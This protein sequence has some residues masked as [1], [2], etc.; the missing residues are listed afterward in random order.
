MIKT[1]K[2]TIMKK[3]LIFCIMLSTS[4]LISHEPGIY[5]VKQENFFIR[6]AQWF[7]FLFPKQPHGVHTTN[8][9]LITDPVTNY[10]TTA[11]QAIIHNRINNIHASNDAITNLFE[12]IE[13][14]PRTVASWKSPLTGDNVAHIICRQ[15][16]QPIHS[17]TS[18]KLTDL[19]K[20]LRKLVRAGLNINQKNNQTE[21]PLSTTALLK[22]STVD[23]IE[24]LV[25]CGA[26]PYI[27][28]TCKNE[29]EITPQPKTIQTIDQIDTSNIENTDPN[30]TINVTIN[31]SRN[32]SPTQHIPDYSEHPLYECTKISEGLK[33]YYEKYP[34]ESYILKS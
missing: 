13:T 6:I 31:S 25:Q 1:L 5:E 29:K 27:L 4:P 9:F 3:L 32:S 14:D 16:K 8:L 2:G 30:T 10:L 24:M 28:H 34:H 18:Y 12:Y 21:T 19:K 23:E 11:K 20:I 33:N 15:L 22:T 7:G 26:S 17:K